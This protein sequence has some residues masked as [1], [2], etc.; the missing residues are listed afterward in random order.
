MEG[1]K[2]LPDTVV[3]YGGGDHQYLRAVAQFTLRGEQ[4]YA[5]L[6]WAR[7]TK[8]H[9]MFVAQFP[10]T[11]PGDVHARLEEVRSSAVIP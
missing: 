9:V 6:V 5:P 2:I 7:S 11:Y 1:W 3:A 8:S 4:W 10:A